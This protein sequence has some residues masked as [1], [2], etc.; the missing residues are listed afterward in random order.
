MHNYAGLAQGE[1]EVGKISRLRLPTK[2]SMR[3][4]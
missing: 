3:V 2:N 4:C 1:A